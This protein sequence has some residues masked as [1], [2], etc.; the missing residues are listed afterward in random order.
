M[1]RKKDQSFSKLQS[2]LFRNSTLV[3][4]EGKENDTNNLFGEQGKG[5]TS[6][7]AKIW[8]GYLKVFYGHK[9]LLFFGQWLSLGLGVFLILSGYH[10][11]GMF[12][13]LYSW[14]STVFTNV[15]SIM[16]AQR[17]MMF[18]VVEIKKYF[19]LLDIVPDIDP[20]ES[21]EIIDSF[22]GEI[23]FK[24]VS[25]AYPYRDAGNEH[26][27]TAADESGENDGKKEENAVKDVSFKIPAGAKVGF[28]GISGSGKSTMVN[29]MRRFYDA[30][31]GQ[32]LIDGKPL[33][34]N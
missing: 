31:E 21:G 33:K 32:I 19:Q 2:E 29:L 22:R 11:V 34:K 20:N 8:L 30:S 28:V 7:S 17:N 14:L 5:V 13:T 3:I 26:G 16:A 4:S 27:E 10:T 23:E 25:F 24:N 12:V 18:R 1:L 6:F 15:G 9:H